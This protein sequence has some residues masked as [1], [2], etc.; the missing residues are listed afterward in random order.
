MR[1]MGWFAGLFLVV[2]T[3]AVSAQTPAPAPASNEGTLQQRLRTPAPT[4][5][6]AV[7]RVTAEEAARLSDDKPTLTRP[8][9]RGQSVAL[10]IAG[11][12]LFL[13]GVLV[14]GDAGAVL[15]VTGALVG[16]YGIYLHFR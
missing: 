8:A 3:S 12:A 14:E 7:P 5:V 11:G 2:F 1:R 9:A 15:M 6:E 16:A 4:S 13:A 10:M